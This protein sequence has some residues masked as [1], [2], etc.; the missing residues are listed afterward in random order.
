MMLHAGEILLNYVSPYARFEGVSK[1]MLARMEADARALGVSSM[2]LE[3][4][5]TARLFYLS[6][7]YTAVADDGL[8]LR[9]R[10]GTPSVRSGAAP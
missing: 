7:G 4:T 6:A 8:M 5:R 2:I 10:L 1:A 9:K 3:S